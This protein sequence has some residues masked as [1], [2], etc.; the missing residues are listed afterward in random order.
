MSHLLTSLD[1]FMEQT[2]ASLVRP[3]YVS[4]VVDQCSCNTLQSLGQGQIQSKISIVIQF[5]ELP[6]KLQHK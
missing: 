6:R 2:P 4:L 5:I 1:G 3:I